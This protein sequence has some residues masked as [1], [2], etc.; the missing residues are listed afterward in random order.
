MKG[1]WI[2]MRNRRFYSRHKP[3]LVNY[4]TEKETDI[5]K[6]IQRGVVA[7]GVDTLFSGPIP[8]NPAELLS[9]AR[10]DELFEILR[11]RYD[12]IIIDGSPAGMVVDTDLIKR[13][14]DH[15]CFMIRARK[16]DKRMTLSVCTKKRPSPACALS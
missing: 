4:L 5:D 6:L 15:T 9:S 12:Y 14:A 2:R 1:S 13:V 16:F 11:K 10:F 3:G 7:P 8:P